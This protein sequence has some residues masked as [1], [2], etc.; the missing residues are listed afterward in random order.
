MSVYFGNCSFSLTQCLLMHYGYCISVCGCK[1]C[2]VVIVTEDM[3]LKAVHH[4]LLFILNSAC[5]LKIPIFPISF[6]QFYSS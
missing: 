6:K 4:I 1:N 2:A 3:N 5:S